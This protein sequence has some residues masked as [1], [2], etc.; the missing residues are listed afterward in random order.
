MRIPSS[1]KTA[2]FSGCINAKS[3]HRSA[4]SSS[5]EAS[6]VNARGS[7]L[8]APSISDG[9]GPA[10]RDGQP[11]HAL[12]RAVGLLP[13]PGPELAADDDLPGDR[14]RVEHEREEDPELERDLVR[15]DRRLAEA[16]RDGA[17]EDERAH[18][19][20]RP[21]ED[22]LPE[23]EH[24]AREAEAQPSLARGAS[25]RRI[26]T[27]KAAPMPEL[28]DRGPPR[29]ALDPPAEPV[30]EDHLEDDVRRIR[31]TRITSGVRRS[32]MP[33]RYPCAAEGEERRGQ[34]DRGYAQVRD[35][36]VRRV[37]LAAHQRDE[38]LGEHGD[39]HRDRDAERER[40]PDGLRAE[41]PGRLLL[42][43]APRSRD[44]RGRP[45]LEEVEDRE[46]AAEDRRR[47]S[48]ARRAAGGRGARRSRCRRG[49]RAAPRRARP[50]QGARA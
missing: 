1:A 4:A 49:G 31:A 48:R 3:G 36:V 50:A 9:K 46:D 33:R 25:P 40:Q 8:R 43:G 39:E 37:S 10:E 19:R 42:P 15:A 14:D 47:R 24:A 18:Q 6:P 23:R 22:P 11:D 5:T 12:A 35:R 44:L 17:R 38:R 21:D 7:T 30:H 20:G 16:R 13:A 27:R 41:P 45:V 28:R 2:P 32:E 26:T 34:P 29:R